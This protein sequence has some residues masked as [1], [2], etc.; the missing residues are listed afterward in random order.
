MRRRYVCR[1]LVSICILV[2]SL[3]GCHSDPDTV[4]QLKV[5]S[6]MWNGWDA[7]YVP[8]EGVDLLDI[9]PRGRYTITGFVE[10]TMELKIRRVS[11]DGVT[12]VT[13]ES[14]SI[15]TEEGY[16]LDECYTKFEIKPGETLSLA[17]P[18]YD[19]GMIFEFE[20]IPCEE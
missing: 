10:D 6:Y 15:R 4:Y 16:L 2:C 20:L 1:M 14:L 13:S 11:D 8:E 17:S 19:G 18:S 5:T 7:Y 9:T 12:F 3:S